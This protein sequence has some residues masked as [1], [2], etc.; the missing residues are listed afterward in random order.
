MSNTISIDDALKLAEIMGRI[1]AQLHR[2]N[3]GSSGEFVTE[4]AQL[5]L[6]REHIQ[7]AL[8]EI[9][10]RCRYDSD[11]DYKYQLQFYPPKT[12]ET[13]VRLPNPDDE[14]CNFQGVDLYTAV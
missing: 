6:A 14:P 11:K 1:K 8:D 5:R 4:L 13:A 9:R 2:G 7:P 12:Q 10:R 3:Y